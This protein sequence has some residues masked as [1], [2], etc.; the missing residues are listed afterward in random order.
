MS[1]ATWEA[2]DFK[3]HL[4]LNQF[5]LPYIL[6]YLADDE[7]ITVLRVLHHARDVRQVAF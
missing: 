7:G 1:S 3:Q 6:F 5:A 2:V 4:L